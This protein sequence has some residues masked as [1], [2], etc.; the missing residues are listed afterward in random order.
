MLI[1]AGHK[2]TASPCFICLPKR[3]PLDFHPLH[4]WTSHVYMVMRDMVF[5]AY[6][7]LDLPYNTA[8]SFLVALYLL[9]LKF[10]IKKGRIISHKVIHSPLPSTIKHLNLFF[11]QDQTLGNNLTGRQPKWIKTLFWNLYLKQ[12]TSTIYMSCPIISKRRYHEYT[13]ITNPTWAAEKTSFYWL[14]WKSSSP[15]LSSDRGT[16]AIIWPIHRQLYEG[17][18]YLIKIL[19][20]TINTKLW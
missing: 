2:K 1:Q 18:F 5:C 14:I 4:I 3:R 10:S 9:Q 11:W 8:V 20:S 12:A 13:K 16:V 7:F 6:S 19:N 17:V 15:N